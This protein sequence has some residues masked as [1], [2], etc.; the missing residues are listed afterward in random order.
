M[1][2]ITATDPLARSADVVADHVEH[3]KVLFPDAFTEG[4]VDFDVL[5]QLLGDIVDNR[6][7][8]FGLNWHG[9]RQAR[10]IALTPSAGTLR[11]CPS[12][13]VDW[14]STK[15]IL[16]EGDNLE[17]L[18]LL[19]K[20]YAGKVKVVF[21]DPPYNTGHD[22]IYPDSFQS[23]INNYLSLTG[24]TSEE[25]ARFG[26]NPE[27]SGRFHTDWLN[28]MLPRLFAARALLS[29]GG[30]VFITI[31][32][33]EVHHLRCLM[34][35]VFGEDNF[36]ATCAWQKVFAK[37]NKAQISGSHDHVLVYTK[38]IDHWARNLLPRDD[39]QLEAFKNPDSDPRG[40]WQSVSFS[41]QSE[42]SDRRA[43]YRYKVKLPSG[44]EVGPPPGRH[45]NGL[46]PR[47]EELKADRRIWFGSDGDSPPRVKLFLSE[48]QDGIVPDT[49]WTHDDVGNNQDAKKEILALFGD[50]E[51]FSTPK[52][53]GLVRRA[54][55][56]G[57]SDSD[58]DIVLDFFAGSG[59]T[60]HAVLAQ[61]A[62]SG[63][64]RRYI[65]VQIPE[66]AGSGDYA[67]IA[68]ITA[69]R[70]RRAGR[71][72]KRSGPATLDAGFRL[73]KL[74]ASNVVAWNPSPDDVGDLLSRSIENIL[75]DRSEDDLLFELML[76]LGLELTTPIETKKVAGKT[77]YS[78]GAGVLMACLAPKLKTTD[79]EA[80]GLGIVNWHRA[81]APTGETTIVFRDSA[82]PDDVA[83]TNLT[84]IL[85]QAGIQNVRSL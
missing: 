68:D 69:E 70:L 5:R 64:N 50:S 65:L 85:E 66:P 7:E 81:Q 73:F 26:S 84:A 24:Q 80:L 25:G 34:D 61:N 22:F 76:K 21:I 4:K 46:P 53:V 48:V 56:I 49:W 39:K 15:N 45:W 38:S 28:M 18:K 59:T 82:F 23:S 74:A 11:P 54:L 52:P 71:E 78:I 10:Q 63:G 83:K 44:R 41:V 14:E 30:S 37:K 20:S 3:L 9:K 27:T 12:G 33:H 29:D 47:Y 58:E 79:I 77:V 55:Q 17:V 2:K 40:R 35:S 43:A 19:Q 1:K 57:T 62:A 8:K 6:E 51:P 13:S 36:V 60:G 42:D 75:P 31:D 32:D 67:T 72:I 16:I